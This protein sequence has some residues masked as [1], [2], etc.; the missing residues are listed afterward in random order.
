VEAVFSIWLLESASSTKTFL[1]D[2]LASVC[3]ADL[4]CPLIL[5]TIFSP[6]AK[7]SR[8]VLVTTGALYLLANGTASLSSARQIHWRILLFLP[9]TFGILHLSYGSG[10]LGNSYTS[11]FWC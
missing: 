9:V 10:V 1:S 5:T 4:C 7:V 6:I 2:A 11:G 3:S 8:F